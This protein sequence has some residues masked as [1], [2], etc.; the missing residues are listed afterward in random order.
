MCMNCC[1]YALL[2]N[3]LSLKTRRRHVVVI[4]C[5][6]IDNLIGLGKNGGTRNAL[7]KWDRYIRANT[8]ATGC[9]VVGL[10]VKVTSLAI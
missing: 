8:V 2:L 10:D 9:T 3:S 4:V 1:V 6:T 5:R 7:R